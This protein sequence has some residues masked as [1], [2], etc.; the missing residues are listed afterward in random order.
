MGQE[1]VSAVNAEALGAELKAIRGDRTLHE[2]GQA[3]RI[4]AGD[5]SKIER[6]KK[7]INEQQLGRLLDYYEIQGGQR[8]ALVELITEDRINAWWTRYKQLI[9]PEFAGR[10][11]VEALADLQE[12]CTAG[13]FTLLLQR[14]AYARE[15]IEHSWD[16]PSPDDLE[17][18]LDIRQRRQQRLY[19][20]PPLRL[21]SIFSEAALYSSAVPEILGDQ[22]KHMLGA[23]RE[24]RVVLQMVPFSAGRPGMLPMTLE[25][26]TCPGEGSPKFV[27]AETLNLQYV[28]ESER[29]NQRF[30]RVINRIRTV[31]L[32]PSDT[33]AKIEDRLKE[34]T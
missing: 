2:V 15:I 34:I 10:L 20:D 23:V 26:L 4:N 11:A 31:A 16:A 17:V 33:F 25:R 3:A 5:L 13:T 19:D 29:D 8:E 6:G 32:S 22:L 30:N 18:W 9:W 21:H 7:V 1:T 12:D 14:P 27:F 28:R 24:G